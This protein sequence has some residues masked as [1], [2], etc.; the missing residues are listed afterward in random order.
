MS[1][2][3]LEYSI[4]VDADNGIVYEKIFGIWKKETAESYKKDF[5]EEV[6]PIID[7]PWVKLID[8]NNWKIGYPEVVDIIGQ[9]LAW[10]RKHNMV[11]SV[12]VINATATYKQLQRMFEKGG[13]KKMS[14][15][16]RNHAE[17]VAFLRQKG[18]EVRSSGDTSRSLRR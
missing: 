14:K 7:K 12:N 11:W 18:F 16:F 4:D 9:H 15:T 10:C 13:T 6:T 2:W 8:L 5:E 1:G 3:S 17:G